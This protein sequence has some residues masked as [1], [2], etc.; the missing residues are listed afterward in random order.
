MKNNIRI[1]LLS[2]LAAASVSCHKED[3]PD[4]GKITV[5]AVAEAAPD[6]IRDIR[7]CI[8][9]NGTL[10]EIKELS[11]AGDGSYSLTA[12]RRDSQ[13]YI[14]ANTDGTGIWDRIEEG[15]T[16]EKDL[17]EM[18]LTIP[19]DASGSYYTTVVSVGKNLSGTTAARLKSSLAR[20]DIETE[21]GLRITVNSITLRN[22][23][24]ETYLLHNTN[25]IT[26]PENAVRSD[27]HRKIGSEGPVYGALYVCE[28][29]GDNLEAEID[30]T[31]GNSNKTVIAALPSELR[32]NTCYTLNLKDENGNI[33]VTVTTDEWED[34]ENTEIKP[35]FSD[36]IRIDKEASS[37]PEGTLFNATGDGF[38]VPHLAGRA[39]LALDCDNIVDVARDENLPFSIEADGDAY[40]RFIIDFP[41]VPVGHSGSKHILHFIRKGLDNYYFEDSVSVT[42]LP[43]PTI[44]E[45]AIEFD[46]ETYSCHFGRYIDGELSVMTL[47]EGK[48]L[49]AEF[50]EGEDPWISITTGEEEPH[51]VRILGGWRPNDPKADGREQT[52]RLVIKDLQSGKEEERYTVSRK[53]YGMPVTFM[54]GVWWCKYN[55]RGNARSFEDQILVNDDPAAAKGMTVL[56]YLNTC[57]VE[58]YLDLWGWAYRG[59]ANGKRIIASDG[60]IKVEN[61]SSSPNYN[62]NLADPESLAPDGYRVPETE[63]Y[64]RLFMEWWMYI[65]RNNGP[66]RPYSPWGNNPNV[67]VASGNRTDLTIGEI[68][69]PVTYHFEVYNLSGNEKNES[70]TFYGPGAQWN[71]NGINHNKI[72]FTSHSANGSGWFNRFDAYGLVHNGGGP[73]DTRVLRLIKTPVEYIY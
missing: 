42:I 73:G 2:A 46:P 29:Y 17:A 44:A 39:I 43:N 16:T 14:L 47:P 4:S 1:L 9:E 18:T 3:N 24:M 41:L 40:N 33:S 69:L 11:A 51:K 66:H 70:V 21:E 35:G 13:I 67:T 57:T 56:E 25:D 58:E 27:M 5:T 61:Y 38:T 28:Q 65:D 52:V 20:I 54:N 32:R 62:I 34:G 37:L 8:F 63:Y 31:A 6:N 19:E 12:K 64:D 60:K 10:T 72:L 23:V 50:P 55:A 7:G 15:K 22:A 26:V 48:T 71:N 59:D 68:Q 36:K 45:G 30:L 49:V 53:N